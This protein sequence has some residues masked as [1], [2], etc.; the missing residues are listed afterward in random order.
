MT[1]VVVRLP[2]RLYVNLSHFHLL[3][4]AEPLEFEPNLLQLH[5]KIYLNKS[6]GH[7]L[8]KGEK[9]TNSRNTLKLGL[10]HS[11][12]NVHINI[13][14]KSDQCIIQNIDPGIKI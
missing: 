2:V 8:S 10:G 5:W 11:I 12:K 4:H 3:L 14:N 9:T 13:L 6:K 1:V 7:T